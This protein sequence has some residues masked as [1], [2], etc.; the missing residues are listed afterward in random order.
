MN[1]SEYRKTLPGAISATF[2]AEYIGCPPEVTTCLGKQDRE[3]GGNGSSGLQ[4]YSSNEQASA[5]NFRWQPH[6]IIFNDMATTTRAPCTEGGM[7][8]RLPLLRIKLFGPFAAFELSPRTPCPS[9]CQT[10]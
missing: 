1:P 6:F 7:S 2:P 3:E 8:R 10:R 5:P 9:A 4:S